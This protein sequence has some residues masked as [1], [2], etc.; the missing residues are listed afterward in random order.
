MF[1]TTLFLMTLVQP[2]Y[3]PVSLAGCSSDTA[4]PIAQQD[5]QRLEILKV[6]DMAPEFTVEKWDKG[7]LKLSDRKDKIAVVTFWNSKM[8][9]NRLVLNHLQEINTKMKADQPYVLMYVNTGDDQATYAD[10]M[11]KNSGKF[12][13][14]WG[15]D[16]LGSSDAN[17]IA[18]KW[19]GATKLPTT[20]VVGTTGRIFAIIQGYNT[21]DM[22]YTS[23][24]RGAGLKID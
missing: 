4:Y 1:S 20:Y 5:S 7:E 16:P 8:K 6:G 23:A 18:W 2:P 19:Y 10:F 17:S 22:R 21:G 3:Q 9:E 11:T 14:H 15:Y 12:A 24:L 13:G